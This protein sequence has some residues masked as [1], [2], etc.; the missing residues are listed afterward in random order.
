MSCANSVLPVFMTKPS[1]QDPRG[2]RRAIQIRPSNEVPEIL[3][4]QTLP[5]EFGSA[6]RTVVPFGRK[7]PVRLVGKT[8]P[9]GRSLRRNRLIHKGDLLPESEVKENSNF[10]DVDN[11]ALWI[12][13][14]F[15][16]A[17]PT[18]SAPH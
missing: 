8:R 3:M 4:G 11:P 16:S 2:K 7:L 15:V 18:F 13:S 14:I 9:F 12:N 10:S 6:N 1:P 5:G 17:S